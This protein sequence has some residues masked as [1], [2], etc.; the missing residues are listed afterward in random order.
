M[1][2]TTKA[3]VRAIDWSLDTDVA[4]ISYLVSI[5]TVLF[6]VLTATGLLGGSAFQIS[7][8]G[9]VLEID[10]W[11]SFLA[12]GA[13]A[14][15]I[16]LIVKKAS[17]VIVGSLLVASMWIFAIITYVTAGLWGFAILGF[18]TANYFAY[19]MFGATMGRLWGY[20]PYRFKDPDKE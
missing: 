14:V 11:G 17:P 8:L 4:P 2:N 1:R 16:G 9:P 18:V 5:H 3:I 20:V 12:V 10:V 13:L 19:F 7:Q 15:L 6:G